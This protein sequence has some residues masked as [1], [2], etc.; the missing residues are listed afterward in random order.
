MTIQ[1][2]SFI[3]ANMVAAPSGATHFKIGSAGASINFENE[4]FEVVTS[5]TAE[6][7][8]NGAATAVINLDNTIAANTTHPLLLALRIE[9]Y[10]QV[11]AGL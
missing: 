2:P 4:T 6:L 8:W 1:I 3:P 7:P 9:F 10:H 5:A 11:M